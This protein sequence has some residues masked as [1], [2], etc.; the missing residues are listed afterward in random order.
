MKI[1]RASKHHAIITVSDM[2]YWLIDGGEGKLEI[3]APT[4]PLN[5]T[6][7]ESYPLNYIPMGSGGA[8]LSMRL[9]A[10]RPK[11]EGE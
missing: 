11:Q 6:C 3:T 4:N 5:N 10:L 7:A 9:Q 8:V 1:K 2:T